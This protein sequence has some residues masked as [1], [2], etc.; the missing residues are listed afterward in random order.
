MDGE[1]LT[2]NK[3]AMEVRLIYTLL[4]DIL[5]YFRSRDNNHK[6]KIAIIHLVLNIIRLN[7]AT[8][9]HIAYSDGNFVR[10]ASLS[11]NYLTL[12]EELERY[13]PILG[14]VFPADLLDMLGSKA[15]FWDR[16]QTF[17]HN[18]PLLGLIPTLDELDEL[19]EQLLYK[20]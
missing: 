9:N 19:C 3:T 12:K 11:Q 18:Q 2:K 7:E 6:E 1:F 13:N 4:K 8:R 20:L 17:D 10:S 5:K 14:G 15:I 16:P